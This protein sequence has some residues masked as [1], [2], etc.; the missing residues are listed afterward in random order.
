MTWFLDAKIKLNGFRTMKLKTHEVFDYKKLSKYIA[1]LILFS[2]DHG[3][4]WNNM[5]FYY[6][7]NT[8]LLEPIAYDSNCGFNNVLIPSN[9][10]VLMEELFLNDSIFYYIYLKELHRVSKDEYLNS[11][12]K[13][14][15]PELKKNINLLQSEFKEFS[16]DKEFFYKKSKIIKN[17][18]IDATDEN[19]LIAVESVDQDTICLTVKNFS[20]L[21]VTINQIEVLD[22][23]IE[24]SNSIIPPKLFFV[25]PKE[26]KFKF[27]NSEII[28]NKITVFY[29][30][31]GSNLKKRLL[32]FFNYKLSTNLKIKLL[33]ERFEI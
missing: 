27:K 32:L 17:A 11:F 7:S 33:I 28:N 18:L 21:P 8:K 4:L 10:N 30:I 2:G 25:H 22:K 5:R 3:F 1:N 29:S 23:T 20:L 26:K 31:L 13:S 9:R 15:E 14:I 12:F 16:F 19:I 6:N 24:L